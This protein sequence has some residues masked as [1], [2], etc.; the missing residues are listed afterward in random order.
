MLLLSSSIRQRTGGSN[1]W[2]P[3][4]LHLTLAAQP[5]A[6]PGYLQDFDTLE[7]TEDQRMEMLRVMKRSL[8]VA[9]CTTFSHAK[10]SI[11]HFSEFE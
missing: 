7:I 10:L 2:G 9:V 4:D 11:C 8:A 5:L 3:L 1:Q 6:V